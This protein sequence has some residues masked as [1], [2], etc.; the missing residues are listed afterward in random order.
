MTRVEIDEE[1]LLILDKELTAIMICN[2][3]DADPVKC[4]AAIVCQAVT[5]GVPIIKINMAMIEKYY[6]S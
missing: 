1:T 3:F 5:K 2:Q 4:L 6:N